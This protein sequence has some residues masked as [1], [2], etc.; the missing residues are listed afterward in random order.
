MPDM[1]TASALFE[2]WMSAP[3]KISA[4]HIAYGPMTFDGFAKFNLAWFKGKKYIRYRRAHF[5]PAMNIMYTMMTK[6]GIPSECLPINHATIGETYL[7]ATAPLFHT[8]NHDIWMQQRQAIDRDKRALYESVASLNG[9]VDMMWMS[10]RLS[11][12]SAD[13]NELLNSLRT[14]G[15]SIRSSTVD[16]LMDMSF[17]SLNGSMELSPELG[18]T[19]IGGP[20]ETNTGLVGI[21]DD[22]SLSAVLDEALIAS[23]TLVPVEK[24]I[25]FGRGKPLQRHPGNI[26]F[27]T[28]ISDQ[29]EEYN[30]S[31]K[32]RQTELSRY[33]IEVIKN[34]G[35]RFWKE[36]DG[37]WEIVSDE[38]AREKVAIT[39][40]TERK[41]RRKQGACD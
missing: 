4:Y 38:D 12:G 17:S 1:R 24:D 11:T 31:D 37:K 41:K 14:S 7:E 27:R 30:D 16:M 8:Y 35:R 18:D 9:A 36:Q 25:K 33:I 5:D 39:F 26:W 3:L 32:K 34:Q 2:I 22:D 15:V 28:L 6:Y 23:R 19:L 13:V 40:R 29:F 10:S 21:D 20:I